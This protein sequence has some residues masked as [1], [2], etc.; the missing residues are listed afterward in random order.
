M[1]HRRQGSEERPDL[2]AAH[3]W[4]DVGQIVLA[5]LF[6][7]IWTAD[8]FFLRYTTFINAQV[9]S[10][11][12]IAIGIVNVLVAIYLA[13]A[14]HRVLLGRTRDDPQLIRGVS[15]ASFDTQCT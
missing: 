2:L 11:L 8:T 13:I 9:P 10:D 4:G 1:A 3:P 12:R 14:S 15:L 5:A 7:A 6:L